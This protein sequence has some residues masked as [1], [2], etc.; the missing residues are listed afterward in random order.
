MKAPELTS[1]QLALALMLLATF[2]GCDSSTEPARSPST[3]L[4]EA[5]PVTFP[6]V[7][8]ALVYNRTKTNPNII[9]ARFVLYTDGTFARQEFNKGSLATTGTWSAIVLTGGLA[10]VETPLYLAE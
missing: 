3:P 10:A 2:S 8:D 6:T 7:S 1:L 9:A 4:R 5:T